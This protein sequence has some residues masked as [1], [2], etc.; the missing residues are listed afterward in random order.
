MP[1]SGQ[2]EWQ[3]ACNGEAFQSK[4]GGP[5]CWCCRRCRRLAGPVCVGVSASSGAPRHGWEGGSNENERY[6]KPHRVRDLAHAGRLGCCDSRCPG[7]AGR[8]GRL[9]Q[10]QRTAVAAVTYNRYRVIM[11]QTSNVK[12]SAQLF[13]PTWSYS[14]ALS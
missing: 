5:K 9:P 8:E 12:Q 14:T 1:S 7:S 4:A 13:C 2:Q 10:L 3:R 6:R 11:S